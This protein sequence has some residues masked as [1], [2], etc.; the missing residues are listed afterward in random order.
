MT[1]AVAYRP[2]DFG[3]AALEWA[4]AQARATASHRLPAI[5]AASADDPR[6]RARLL[7]RSGVARLTYHAERQTKA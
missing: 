6:I 7:V 3:R 5:A 2:D 4:A 1:I